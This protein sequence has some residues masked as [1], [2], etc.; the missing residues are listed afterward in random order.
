MRP[1]QFLAPV[2]ELEFLTETEFV[3][4][5]LYVVLLERNCRANYQVAQKWPTGDLMAGAATFIVSS[6]SPC[7]HSV[8]AFLVFPADGGSSPAYLH[9]TVPSHATERPLP[10]VTSLECMAAALP[11]RLV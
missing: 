4:Y 9:A 5:A 1:N 8:A 10:T 7:V 2:S 3:S 11:E 6:R